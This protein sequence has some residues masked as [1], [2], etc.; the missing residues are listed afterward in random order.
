V[1]D[2]AR[3]DLSKRL[4]RVYDDDLETLASRGVCLHSD[5]RGRIEKSRSWYYSDRTFLGS[6]KPFDVVGASITQDFV[7]PKKTGE[8]G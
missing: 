5:R 6:D 1:I 7:K 8:Y 3:A 2:T 4:P